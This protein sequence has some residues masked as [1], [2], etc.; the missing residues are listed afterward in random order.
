MK[1]LI[2]LLNLCVLFF[3][4]NF[5]YEPT[6]L[7]TAPTVDFNDDSSIDE[8]DRFIIISIPKKITTAK[9]INVYRQDVTSDSNEEEI[10]NIGIIYPK[11]VTTEGNAY[12]FY[13]PYIYT[14]HKYKYRVRYADTDAYV[15]TKWSQEIEAQNGYDEDSQ[16][17]AYNAAD[18]KFVYDKDS[19][20]LKI[21]GTITPP[22]ADIKNFEKDFKPMIIVKSEEK[23]QVFPIES[24]EDE[25]KIPLRAILSADFLDKPISIIGI[26][27][28]KNIYVGDETKKDA[29]SDSDD[30][31]EEEKIRDTKEIH[32]LKSTELKINKGAETLVIPSS[33]QSSGLDYSKKAY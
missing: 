21:S 1:K 6:S 17:L 24:I 26:V 33:A 2:L 4:C 27:P 15:Y 16:P 3:G 31:E 32:W 10:E 28:Q 11:F 23:T 9:Y 20:N 22:T 13:D 12:I 5:T 18:A 19:Y 30:E 14:G 29:D 8:P 7:S 25:T